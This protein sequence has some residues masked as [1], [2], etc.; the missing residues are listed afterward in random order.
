MKRVR[1]LHTVLRRQG[2]QSESCS[3]VTK[4]CYT[5]REKVGDGISPAS[6]YQGEAG[7]H[8][9]YIFLAHSSG[10]EPLAFAFGGRRSIQLSYE[11]R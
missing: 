8:F 2:Y 7:H 1:A 10:F 9:I 6:A 11:C 3:F 5:N 4:Q